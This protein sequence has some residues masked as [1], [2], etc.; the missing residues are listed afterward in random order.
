MSEES[1]S[2]QILLVDDEQ[3]VRESL[4]YALERD[5]FVSRQAASL[6]EAWAQHEGVDLLV[7]DLML[8]DGSGLDFLRRLR[9]ES[10]VPVIIL[11]S[12]EDEADRVVGLELGADD[13]VVKPFSPREMVARVRAVLRRVAPVSA[14]SSAKLQKAADDDKN[15]DKKSHQGI[16]LD[17]ERRRAHFCGRELQLSKIEFDLLMVLQRSPGRVF[18]RDELLD[19]VWGQDVAIG[20]RTVDVHVKSLR[21]KITAVDGD[22]RII[23]TVRGVGYRLREDEA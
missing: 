8:P 15:E 23:E 22:A 2:A 5:G 3:A 10:A 1:V 19:K 7:L 20:D 12:R 17:A 13:Y 21:K 9:A 11:S 6:A 4:A 14:V 18:A 16:E